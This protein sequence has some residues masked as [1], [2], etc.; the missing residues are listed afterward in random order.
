LL[1]GFH[2]IGGFAAHFKPS[3]LQENPNYVTNGVAIVYH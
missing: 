1:D 2:S 3:M